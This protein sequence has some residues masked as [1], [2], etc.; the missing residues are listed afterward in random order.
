MPTL[1]DTV[2][3]AILPLALCALALYLTAQ[4][5]TLAAVAILP[6]VFAVAIAGAANKASRQAWR[7]ELDRIEAP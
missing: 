1:I 6:L 2:L 5:A 3:G 4:G 7:R